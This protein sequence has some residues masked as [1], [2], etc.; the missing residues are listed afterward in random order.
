MRLNVYDTF[1]D[2]VAML[3]LAQQLQ[4]EGM[5]SMK[6]PHLWASE[7]IETVKSAFDMSRLIVE[8]F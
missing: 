5:E 8:A 4:L 3:K 2:D 6:Q 1:E 7:Q